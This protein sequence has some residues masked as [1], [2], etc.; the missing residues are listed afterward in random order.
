[1]SSVM[2]KLRAKLPPWAAMHISNPQSWKA[3]FRAW[4][5][6]WIALVLLLPDKSLAVLGN[7]AFFTMMTS[8]F[9]PAN[10]PIHTFLFLTSTLVIGLCLGWVFGVVAMRSALAVRDQVLLSQNLEKVA[11]NA[12]GLA[13]PEALFQLAIFKADFLDTRS[14]IMYGF[15]LALGN[16]CFAAMRAYIPPLTLMSIFSI[17]C[18]DIFCSYGPLFPIAEYTLVN[19][20]LTSIG[21]YAGIAVILSLVIY[22]TSINSSSLGLITAQV[23][24]MRDMT[25]MQQSV[26]GED[27]STAAADGKSQEEGDVSAVP[28][29]EKLKELV[30]KI[31]GMRAGLIMGQQIYGMRSKYITTE[32]SFGR[33]SG[34]D[35]YSLEEPLV[36]L[37][38]RML[39]LQNFARLVSE[40]NDAPSAPSEKPHETTNEDASIASAFEGQHSHSSSDISSIMPHAADVLGHIHG[41][42]RPTTSYKI[43][44]TIDEA[45]PYVRDATKDL[46]DAL[47]GGLSTTVAT[48]TAVNNDRLSK[49]IPLLG[50][51]KKNSQVDTAALSAAVANLDTALQEFIARKRLEALEPFRPVLPKLPPPPSP[52]LRAL[53]ICFTFSANLIAVSETALRFMRTVE[54]LCT[55]RTRARVWLPILSGVKEFFGAGNGSQAHEGDETLGEDWSGER[56]ETGDDAVDDWNEKSYGKDPDSGPP[57]NLFQRFVYL[58]HVVYMWLKTPQAVFI[59]KSTAITILLWLPAVMSS[60]AAFY[61]E[62]R[63]VWALIMSQLTLNIYVSDQ[64]FNYAT[65]LLGTFVGLIVGLVAWYIGAGRGIGNPYGIAASCAV[66]L[67]PLMW[68]RMFAPPKYLSG[69]L[70][71]CATFSLIIGYSWIDGHLPMYGNPGIGWSIAWRRWTLVVIGCAASFVLMMLPPVSGRKVVRLRNAKII[72]NIQGLYSILMST[73]ISA[74]PIRTKTRGTVVGDGETPGKSV[75]YGLPDEVVT[76]PWV[77]HM[78][79]RVKA[80]AERIQAARLLTDTARWEGGIRGHWPAEDYNALLDA[81]SEMLNALTQLGSAMLHLDDDWRVKFL[82]RTQVVHPS[83]ISD[84]MS[85]FAMVSMALRTGEPLHAVLPQSLLE[86]LFY[87]HRLASV[88]RH[89]PRNSQDNEGHKAYY[90]SAAEVLEDAEFMHWASGVVAVYQLLRGLDKV[91]DITKRLVGEIPLRGFERWKGQ[92]EQAH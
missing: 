56:G 38:V 41:S 89:N 59:L 90:E 84:V 61:Y 24:K 47:E 11:Q 79:S 36:G 86:R 67:A 77:N 70:T 78:R 69:V 74:A 31:N 75:S 4:L 21:C 19:S 23:V 88:P 48:L 53:F 25:Q 30:K 17:I 9:L 64:L 82:H 80:L 81:E 40:I 16:F 58:F 71:G 43:E 3:F 7:A 2:A 28:V 83:F 85:K 6:S 92:F 14:S 72:K 60:S 87:H 20:L 44:V 18:I 12:A 76:E 10:L 33:W 65:R 54:A 8:F 52:T 1:M 22:P 46:R 45:I 66:F 37:L 15:F 55:R 49:F 39:G 50:G 73:W 57:Q 26:L 62:Q 13:N 51:P 5:A 42:G 68:L 63:G 91:S 35:V 27:T 34:K 32:L 29:S